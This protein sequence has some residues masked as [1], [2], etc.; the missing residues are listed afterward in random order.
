MSVRS[1]IIKPVLTEKSN[2]L[3]E[4]NRYTFIVDPKLNKIEL[5]KVFKILFNV[6]VLK[7]NVLNRKGKIKMTRN[8]ISKSPSRKRI[9]VTL[10]KDQKIDLFEV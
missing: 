3:K 10:P 7:C 5:K 9:V 6:D 1:N 4:K 8:G 2:L